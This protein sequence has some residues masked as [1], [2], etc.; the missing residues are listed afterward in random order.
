MSK[1]TVELDF[2]GLERMRGLSQLSLG[3][4]PIF[5]WDSERAFEDEYSSIVGFDRGRS[6]A[7]F[8]AVSSHVRPRFA[9][10]T[11]AVNFDVRIALPF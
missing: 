11:A 7:A 2:F 9:N 8:D 10:V 3:L 5:F 4:I 6:E 1:S